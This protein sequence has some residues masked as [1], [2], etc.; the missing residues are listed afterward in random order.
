MKNYTS[1]G[2]SP[3]TNY[4]RFNDNGASGGSGGLGGLGGLADNM[5]FKRFEQYNTHE[6]Q[7]KRE[8]NRNSDGLIGNTNIYTTENIIQLNSNNSNNPNNSL[9][10]SA[11]PSASASF[12]PGEVVFR[13]IVIPFY[14]CLM[15][16]I[17]LNDLFVEIVDNSSIET[18]NKILGSGKIRKYR[19]NGAIK[20]YDIFVEMENEDVF[21]VKK[22][23]IMMRVRVSEEIRQLVLNTM[24]NYVA[25]GKDLVNDPHHAENLNGEIIKADV[26]KN[27]GG[28][29][30]CF[31]Y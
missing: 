25:D 12:I 7:Q 17:I 16:I 9:S 8:I 2:S 24:V 31:R 28:C 20:N 10:S 4:I 11:S 14:V 21:H 1:L 18:K 23:G 26:K 3:N 6:T 13:T 30:T 27:T 15:D 19:L 22:R 29:F 5:A